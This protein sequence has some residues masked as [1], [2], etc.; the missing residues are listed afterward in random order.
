M[1]RSL[2]GAAEILAATGSDPLVRSQLRGTRDT[3]PAWAQDGA[4]GW[5]AIDAD[6]A[7]RYFFVLGGR[8][9]PPPGS[10][11]TWPRRS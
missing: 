7:M 8:R 2:D 10:W 9:P 6:L 4:V 3:G 11:T 1:P 5:F